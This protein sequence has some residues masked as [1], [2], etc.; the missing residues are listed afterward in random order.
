MKKYMA[1]RIKK[2]RLPE[3]GNR[4]ENHVTD[5]EDATLVGIYGN[6]RALLSFAINGRRGKE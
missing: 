5:K 1:G 4:S 2:G 3:T 6:I